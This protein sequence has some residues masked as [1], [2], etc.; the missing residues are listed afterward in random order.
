MVDEALFIMPD[1]HLFSRNCDY[2][3]ELLFDIQ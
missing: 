1:L 3:V 2:D